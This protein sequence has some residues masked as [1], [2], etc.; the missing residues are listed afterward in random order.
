MKMRPALQ[1][2]FGEGVLDPDN[3]S[4]S[5]SQRRS[6]DVDVR[7]DGR[8]LGHP[9]VRNVLPH[10][11]IL[12]VHDEQGGSGGIEGFEGVE[13][14]AP[15]HDEILVGLRKCELVHGDLQALAARHH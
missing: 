10:E 15:L 3:A 7:H 5:R 1:R 11:R 9:R 6:Q 13:T 8:G 12:H 14:A 2:F 4:T